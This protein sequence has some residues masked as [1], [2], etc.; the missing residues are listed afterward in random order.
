MTVITK[1]LNYSY[2]FQSNAVT[3]KMLGLWCFMPLSIIFRFYWWWKTTDLQVPDSLTSSH[4]VVY[5]QIWRFPLMC[6]ADTVW[7][8][9][10]TLIHKNIRSVCNSH[11]QVY[12]SIKTHYNITD[13]NNI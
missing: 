2:Q 10:L 8:T 4:K 13:K 1:A 5:R 3:M 12:Q 7:I 11:V 9:E 6:A